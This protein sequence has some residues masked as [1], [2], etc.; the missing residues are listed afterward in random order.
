MLQ[1]I[2]KCSFSIYNPFWCF[3]TISLIDGICRSSG[4]SFPKSLQISP[5]LSFLFYLPFFGCYFATKFSLIMIHGLLQSSFWKSKSFTE[6]FFPGPFS[7]YD[8]DNCVWKIQR[9]CVKLLWKQIVQNPK[10]KTGR[11][12]EH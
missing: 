5:F 12:K 10:Y 9:D 2:R 8:Q 4:T 7:A 11:L 3:V 1:R 6:G